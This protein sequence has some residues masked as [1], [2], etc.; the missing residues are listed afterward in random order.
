MLQL[1]SQYDN[2]NIRSYYFSIVLSMNNLQTKIHTI[3]P[4][5]QLPLTNHINMF[6]KVLRHGINMRIFLFE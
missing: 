4:L 3:I 6:A 5:R 2:S 1:T